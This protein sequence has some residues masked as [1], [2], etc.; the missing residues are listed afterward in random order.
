MMAGNRRWWSIGRIVHLFTTGLKKRGPS[1]ALIPF[2]ALLVLGSLL[3][4]SLLPLSAQEEFADL[5]IEVIDGPDPVRALEFVTYT[6]T[7]RNLG[8]GTAQNVVVEDTQ[9]VSNELFFSQNCQGG[10]ATR[11]TCDVG[12][13]ASGA[14]TVLQ[15][16][17]LVDALTVASAQNSQISNSATVVSNSL[18]P[19][20]GNNESVVET[21]IIA[22]DLAVEITDT[23]DPVLPGQNLA[24]QITVENRGPSTAEAANLVLQGFSP[25]AVFTP[26]A[27]RSWICRFVR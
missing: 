9:P 19:F 12:D 8:P 10:G 17:V 18:D 11:I 1:V 15:I 4:S 22:A 3:L 7:V 24:H 5:S 25:A 13:L 14:S 20:P 23:P 26:P 21:T 2:A 27:H 16:D 6:I